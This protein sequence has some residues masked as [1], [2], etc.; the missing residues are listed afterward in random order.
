M[1][2]NTKKHRLRTA[3]AVAAA[4][5]AMLPVFPG[6]AQAAA[7]KI[8]PGDQ[9]AVLHRDGATSSCSVGPYVSLGDGRYGALTAGH[10]GKDGDPVYWINPNGKAREVGSLYKPVNKMTSAGV[11]LDYGLVPVDS[12]YVDPAIEG[13]RVVDLATL[14]DIVEVRGE[15]RLK[16]C[17]VGNTSGY[18][19]GTMRRVDSDSKLIVA[20]FQSDHGD[21]GGPV[22]VPTDNGAVVVGLLYGGE[23]GTGNS[24]VTPIEL[25]IEAYSVR[26]TVDRV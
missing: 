9:I 3:A 24:L 20:D 18:R 14:D 16:V 23:N 8:N 13:E 17:S 26:L 22:W 19:C 1:N 10:C 4:V 25:P 5:A 7:P 6:T 2:T 15:Q 21:S 12:T 11:S